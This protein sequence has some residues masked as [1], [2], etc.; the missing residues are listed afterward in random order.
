[1]LFGRGDLDDTV[2][3]LVAFAEVGAAVLYAPGLPD[4]D[5]IRTVVRAVAPKP[6]NV[7]IGPRSNP[8]PLSELAAAGVRRVTLGGALYRRA[9]GA[10]RDAAK[11]LRDGDLA[12]ATTGAVPSNEVAALLPATRG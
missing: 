4:L 3:R 8:G 7:L 2:R 9:M 5:A 10:L 12:A 11:A 6:V 1:M